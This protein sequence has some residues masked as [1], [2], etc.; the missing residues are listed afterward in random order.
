MKSSETG[1]YQ[2]A[3]SNP[4]PVLFS[5]QDMSQMEASYE[6]Y[7][8]LMMDFTLPHLMEPQKGSKRKKPERFNVVFQGTA[9]WYLSARIHQDNQN[10]ITMDQARY[11][12]S[13][14]TRYLDGAGVKRIN[15]A[16]NTILPADFMPTVEDKA[17]TM[18]ES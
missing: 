9:H 5:S 2:L 18:E 17:K 16:N 1:Q 7:S 12:K 13:I 8:T 4:I 10:N 14:V 15:S 6:L 11:A 3:L